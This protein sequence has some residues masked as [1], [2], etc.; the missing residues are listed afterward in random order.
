MTFEIM[1][2]QIVNLPMR[3]M[4]KEYGSEEEERAGIESF[5]RQM[6]RI[7]IP[8]MLLERLKKEFDENFKLSVR[9]TS[10]PERRELIK[11]NRATNLY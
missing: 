9:N 7:K 5:D 11:A 4:I 2:T 3:F 1:L 10:S 8:K 6:N